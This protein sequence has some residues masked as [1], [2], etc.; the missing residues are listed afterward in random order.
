VL[1]GAAF[2]E[3]AE[4]VERLSFRTGPYRNEPT[5]QLDRYDPSLKDLPGADDPVKEAQYF[6]DQVSVRTR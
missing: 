5:R 4:T 1:A 2:A 3:A 6:I